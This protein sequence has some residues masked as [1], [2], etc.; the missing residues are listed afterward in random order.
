MTK[1]PAQLGKQIQETP[2]PLEVLMTAITFAALAAAQKRTPVR[3]GLLRRSETTR[4]EAKG[5]RGFL[6]TNTIY[7]PFVH[8]RVP[9]FQQGIQ[10][11]TPQIM[12]LLQHAGDDYLKQFG[13]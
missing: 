8:A 7:A 10:D 12:Q 4:I 13:D 1:T 2:L 5:M 11:A 3:T 9:F 6:G